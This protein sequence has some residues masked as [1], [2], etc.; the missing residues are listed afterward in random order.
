MNVIAGESGIGLLV[1]D[2]EVDTIEAGETILGRKPDV[3]I[4][5]LKDLVNAVLRKPVFRGPRLMTPVDDV[6]TWGDL[7]F[8]FLRAA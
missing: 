2:S 4:L 8:R 5:R 1:E 6:S 7:A 3:T